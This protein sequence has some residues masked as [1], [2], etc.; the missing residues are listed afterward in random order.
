MYAMFEVETISGEIF[1]V[2]A[3]TDYEA[4]QQVALETDELVVDVTFLYWI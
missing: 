4:S 2:E 1:R 3:M